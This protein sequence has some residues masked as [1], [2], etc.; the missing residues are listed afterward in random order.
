MRSK[1]NDKNYSEITLTYNE[2]KG[3]LSTK[4]MSR[5]LKELETRGWIEK[6]KHGGLYGGSCQYKFKGPYSKF[7]YR[8]KVKL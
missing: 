8:K 6:T 2:M 1:F 3:I 4:T 5:A 7:Y